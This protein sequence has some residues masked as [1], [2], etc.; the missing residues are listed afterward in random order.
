MNKTKYVWISRHLIMTLLTDNSNSL[1]PE[2]W[3]DLNHI[4]KAIEHDIS[5]VHYMKMEKF[6]DYF[7][8]T[9]KEK[10]M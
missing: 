7:V 5:Q 1:S 2:E 6:T 4:R 3:E 10:G 9:L 8:R